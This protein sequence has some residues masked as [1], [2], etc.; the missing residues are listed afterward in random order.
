MKICILGATGNSGRRLVRAALDRGHHVTALVRDPAKAAAFAHERLNVHAPSFTD[1]TALIEALRGHDAVINAAG[2]LGDGPAFAPLVQSIIRATDAALE[3][4]GRFWLFGGAALLDV[5]GTS[6]MTIDLP[7]VPSVYEAHRANLNAVSAT[8][9]DW[10]MLCPGPML[11]APDEKPTKGPIVSAN[12]WPVA[13]PPHT[14]VLP[15]VALSLAFKNAMPRMTIYYED[16]AAII[17]DNLEPDGPF[18]RKRVGIALPD[19][20]RRIKKSVPT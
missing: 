16:A 17:L 10:S 2:Y 19:N 9:L 14:H 4:G 18:Q 20:A 11:D 6:I 13:R 3:A 15:R 1:S 5:P 8:R 7:G 12:V